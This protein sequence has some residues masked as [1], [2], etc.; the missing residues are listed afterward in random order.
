MK[1]VKTISVTGLLLNIYSFLAWQFNNHDS[2][3]TVPALK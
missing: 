3:I 1:T 2:F